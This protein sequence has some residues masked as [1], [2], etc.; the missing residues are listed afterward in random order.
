MPE[1]YSRYAQSHIYLAFEIVLYLIVFQNVTAIVEFWQVCPMV[2][3]AYL[4]LPLALPLTLT[5]TLARSAQWSGR[6]P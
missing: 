3:A 2:W 6:P 4:A 1:L 5:L